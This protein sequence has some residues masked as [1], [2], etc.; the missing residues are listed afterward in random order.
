M[1]STDT[2]EIFSA[3]QRSQATAMVAHAYRFAPSRAYVGDLLASGFIGTP[4]QIA[5]QFFRGAPEKEGQLASTGALAM[6]PEVVSRAV[7]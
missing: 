2:H 3:T 5:I 1:S 6:R 7:K 4:H